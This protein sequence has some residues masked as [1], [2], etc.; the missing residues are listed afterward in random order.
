MDVLFCHGLATGPVGAKSRALRAA[1]H[2]VQAPDGRG[3]DLR[4]RVQRVERA[5]RTAP[6]GTVVVGSSFGGLVALC[7][8]LRVEHQAAGLVLCAPALNV[9]QPPAT[10]MELATMILTIIVHGIRDQ[11]IP[12]QVS[13]DFATRSGCELIECDDDHRLT[14]SLDVILGAVRRLGPPQAGSTVP[15]PTHDKRDKS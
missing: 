9:R 12:V 15:G 5:L 14:G 10:T 1:G 2:R 8:L 11:V 6:A 3:L 13:R 4:Q 7:A